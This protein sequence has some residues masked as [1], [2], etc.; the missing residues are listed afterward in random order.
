MI[1]HRHIPHILHLVLMQNDGMEYLRISIHVA[2][3]TG[4]RK[5]RKLLRSKG[6]DDRDK[7]A[8]LLT[9]AVMET[10]DQYEVTKNRDPFVR[11]GPLPQ[12][13]L[14]SYSICRSS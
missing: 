14:D 3:R 13:S 11:T 10:L 7:T 2:L 5:T 8:S 9:D 4:L 1:G 6:P 12:E